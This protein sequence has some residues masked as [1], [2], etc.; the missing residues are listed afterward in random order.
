LW[1]VTRYPFLA[2]AV[3]AMQVVERP[4][5]NTVAVDA[6]F[7]LYLDGSYVRRLSTVDLGK[8][9]I[10]HVGHLLRVHAERAVE[11]DVVS[12]LA[13]LWVRACD[14][15][16]N[17]D[18]PEDDLLPD[19]IR[20]LPQTFGAAPGQFAEQYYTHLRS[21]RGLRWR[22]WARREPRLDCGS[23]ADGQA[24]SWDDSDGGIDTDTAAL[25]R[26]QVAS[27]VRAHADTDPD[28]VDGSWMRWAEQALG[29][30][31]DWRRLLAAEI[32]RGLHSAP[33]LSD[34]TH[35]RP[36]RRRAATPGVILPSLHQPVPSLAIV[37]DTSASMD[38]ALLAEALT[39]VDTIVRA[40]TRQRARVP[41]IACDS[42]V[43]AV[44]YVARGSDV[45]L[46]G[47]GTTDLA[48][49]I[50]AAAQLRPR[51]SLIAVLTDG[52]TRWPARPPAGAR[53]VVGLLAR[54]GPTHPL[55]GWARVIRVPDS[56][57]ASRAFSVQR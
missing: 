38:Q 42:T 6:G 43:R 44:R 50:D 36:S 25:I 20:T 19:H 27:A 35:R 37:C 5:I 32:R 3:F 16:I 40:T 8:L 56:G 53:V 47:G 4:G 57:A 48:A 18:L 23:A 29:V 15:E 55:P 24:R 11:A 51:P 30:R 12:D 52:E 31:I 17:D 54:P 21:R 45:D 7:R 34:Y 28:A 10:H 2:A 26:I 33:G 1:T 13:P 46:S 22:T 39:H 14:A 49:G 41:V 9:L